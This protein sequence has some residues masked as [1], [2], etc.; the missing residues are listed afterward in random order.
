MSAGA[1]VVAY[2]VIGLIAAGIASSLASFGILV[3]RFGDRLY[4]REGPLARLPWP[5]IRAALILSVGVLYTY[6][7]AIA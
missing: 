5:Y 6:Q 1:P 3:Q 7:A 2:A 4:N